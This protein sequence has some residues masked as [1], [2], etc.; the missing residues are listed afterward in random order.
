M[1]TVEAIAARLKRYSARERYVERLVAPS[2]AGNE[3]ES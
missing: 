1:P 3:D 2:A